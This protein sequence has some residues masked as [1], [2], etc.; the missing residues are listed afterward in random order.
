MKNC[1]KLIIKSFL[2]KHSIIS[3]EIWNP[4]RLVELFVKCQP[5]RRDASIYFN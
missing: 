3:N 2:M 5:W 4:V 1:F